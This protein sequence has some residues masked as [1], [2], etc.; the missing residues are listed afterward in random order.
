MYMSQPDCVAPALAYG[1][2]RTMG[3]VR[4]EGSDGGW[5]PGVRF[6]FFVG[7][8]DTDSVAVVAL[9]EGRG[10]F[11][12]GRGGADAEACLSFAAEIPA[13]AAAEA[14]RSSLAL[15]GLREPRFPDTPSHLVTASAGPIL[16]VWEWW[17]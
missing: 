2:D 5:A 1:P 9:V 7:G 6:D 12:L 11:R 8:A 14:L 13:A 4:P 16:A 15:R 10:R 17:C 3:V